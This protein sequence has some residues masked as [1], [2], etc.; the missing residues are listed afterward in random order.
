M[1]LDIRVESGD[2]LQASAVEQFVFSV[3]NNDALTCLFKLGTR[4]PSRY[5][6]SSSHGIVAPKTA[7]QISVRLRTPPELG[8]DD[9]ASSSGARSSSILKNSNNG[10]AA[11]RDGSGSILSGMPLEPAVFLDVTPDGSVVTSDIL[12][13]EVKVVMGV[14]SA[15]HSA[16]AS[17]SSNEA[18]FKRLWQSEFSHRHSTHMVPFRVLFMSAKVYGASLWERQEAAML[19]LDEE[20]ARLEQRISDLKEMRRRYEAQN[21]QFQRDIKLLEKRCQKNK[22]S[23]KASGSNDASRLKG[24]ITVPW[25]IGLGAALTSVF[26]AAA[27]AIS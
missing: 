16:A 19:A 9:L 26:S 8:H 7:M 27:I 1:A 21:E 17:S 25:W 3:V 2:Q 15:K 14:L 4:H 12:K 24:R 10:T 13:V 23:S 20:K 18:E 6:I 22:G 11:F 5:V